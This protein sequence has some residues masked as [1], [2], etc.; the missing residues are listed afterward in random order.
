MLLNHK[1]LKREVYSVIYLWLSFGATFLY[2]YAYS[3]SYLRQAGGL[4][5]G[6]MNSV[7]YLRQVG[8]YLH[9]YDNSVR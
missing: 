2:W 1:P 9:G 6:C 7:S 4:L 5:Y 3:V 8:G